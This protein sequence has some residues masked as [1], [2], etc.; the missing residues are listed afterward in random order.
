MAAHVLD[1][2]YL[3]ITAIVTVGYQL[4]FFAIAY[5][6]KFDKLTDFAGGSNFIVLAVVTVSLSHPHNGRQLVVTLFLI[7]WAV[8]LTSFLFFRILKTGKDDRFDEMR[9]KF[10]PFLGFWILQM[11][12]VW[13]VSLPVTVLNS[14]AVTRYPQHSFGTGRDI[15]GIVLYSIGLAI[16]AISDAQKYRFRSKHDGQAVCDQGLFAVSRHP[17]YFG[18]IIVHF[19]IYMIAVS[20]AANGFVR[21]QAFK[22]LYATILG[23]FFL[24]FLL[25]F[26]S[27]ISLAERPKAKARY[28]KDNN[29]SGYKRWLDRT[30][31][32]IP[33]PPQLYEKMPTILKRTVFLEFPMY[34]FD[35][36]K[37]SSAPQPGRRVNEGEGEPAESN[38]DDSPQSGDEH[39]IE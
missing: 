18:E 28:E 26:V 3:G 37:H 23:P 1:D 16:E 9:Q 7:A 19:A 13:T 27:G 22:A 25:L 35:P 24:T 4:F 36:K 14:P 11:L 21:G 32:L 15:A 8:R 33:F 6:C 12:W 34:V 17:N 31:V 20:P 39:L 30:S 10:F 38:R 2:Y 29:W 5:A